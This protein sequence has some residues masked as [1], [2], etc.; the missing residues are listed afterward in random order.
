MNFFISMANSETA[1]FLIDHISAES[2]QDQTLGHHFRNNETYQTSQ[3]PS[4]NTV[5]ILCLHLE[6][7]MLQEVCHSIVSI[8]LK[9]WASVD[10]ETNS[11]CGCSRVF[12]GHTQAIVQHCDTCSWHIKECLLIVNSSSCGPPSHRL[13]V[14]RER[15]GISFGHC[16]KLTGIKLNS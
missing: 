1:F 11:G 4:Q 3:C 15:S 6:G 12:S 9:S 13:G 7:H 8:S 16:Q 2:M 14:E 10:P 5:L